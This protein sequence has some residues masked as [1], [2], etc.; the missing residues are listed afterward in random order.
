[1]IIQDWKLTRNA[2]PI[3]QILTFVLGID[4]TK[5]VSKSLDGAIYIQTIGQGVRYANVSIFSSRQE[6]AAVN[7]AE[8][9]GAVVSCVYRDRRYLGYIEA[10]PEWETVLPGEWYQA[11]IKLLIEEEVPV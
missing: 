8:A 6:M 1:M 3:A 9:D 7:S 11:S 5:V 2:V 4:Q 10:A